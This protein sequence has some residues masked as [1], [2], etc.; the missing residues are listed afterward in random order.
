MNIT[1]AWKNDSGEEVPPFG[2]VRVKSSAIQSGGELVFT[3]EKPTGES[4]TFLVNQNGTI[5]DGDNGAYF[6]F[7][8]DLFP[9]K[10]SGT[11]PSQGDIIGPVE[12][13]FAATSDGYGFEVMLG[14]PDDN[15]WVICS[16]VRGQRWLRIETDG[17]HDKGVTQACKILDASDTDT[18][19]T[20]DCKNTLADLEDAIKGY[21]TDILDGWVIIQAECEAS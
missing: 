9:V 18:G 7:N 15:G 16:R 21:A 17:T 8:A 1:S 11:A 20:I 3:C 5:E 4:G 6:P 2:I 19:E 13:S 14:D 10:Y 12:D